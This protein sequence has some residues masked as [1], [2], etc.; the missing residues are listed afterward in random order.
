MNKSVYSI[1]LSDDV[2]RQVD[3]LAYREGTSRSNMVNR[4]LAEY[5]SY[6]TPEQRMRD[7]FSNAA[8]VVEEMEQLQL[9]LRPT[10]THMALK[11][12]LRY[13]YNPTV[14]YSVELY[15]SG[16]ALGELRV[17]MRTQSR[18]LIEAL[19]S[20]F[21]LWAA[22]EKSSIGALPSCSIGDGKYTRVLYQTTNAPGDQLGQAIIDYVTVLDRCMKL[23]FASLSEGTDCQSEIVRIYRE[24]QHNHRLLV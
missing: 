23:Y 5:V 11:S 10:D 16:D 12:A 1:V 6:V 20:F 14:K 15:R 18:S 19:N 22:V 7:I 3:Q 17:T 24:Y 13:K 9:M 2:I 8:R 4:I 21:T